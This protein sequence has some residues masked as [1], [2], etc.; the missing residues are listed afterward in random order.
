MLKKGVYRIIIIRRSIM[1]I[2]KTRSNEKYHFFFLGIV[3]ILL[4]L[5]TN[6][7]RA[8]DYERNV[9]SEEE[10]KYNI[11]ASSE[12]ATK[13]YLEQICLIDSECYVIDKMS[14][15]DIVELACK[16]PFK[17]D[18]L[19]FDDLKNG[20]EHLKETSTVF[21]VLLE[22][23][24]WELVVRKKYNDISHKSSNYNDISSK[25]LLEDLL[26]YQYGNVSLRCKKL[27]ANLLKKI[28]IADGYYSDGEVYIFYKDSAHT[29]VDHTAYGGY[30]HKYGVNV[31]CYSLISG[32]YST[33]EITSIIY[34]Y[35]VAHP[36]WIYMNP[37]TKRYNCHSYAWINTNSSNN[38][39]VNYPTAFCNSSSYVN[40][41][42]TDG[43]ILSAN[44]RVVIR[45]GS[46]IKHS[47]IAEATTSSSNIKQN[48][49]CV[50]KLGKMGVYRTTLQ[51]MYDFYSG[52][53]YDVYTIA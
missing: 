24:D 42:N 27:I 7:V 13:T 44:S 26:Y 52:T 11:V 47:V 41:I 43:P 28:Y 10:N 17:L 20:F 29:I 23:D 34:N 46:E 22:R 8:D 49:E 39:W 38:I 25:M 36:T 2:D 12:W 45:C 30:Y 1:I 51:D 5:L 35:H 15:V 18:Y 31:G 4:W 6:N 50:S 37:P 40:Y 16:Y 33:S 53:S 9:L 21:K 3:L 19:M 14:T 32:D 48:T